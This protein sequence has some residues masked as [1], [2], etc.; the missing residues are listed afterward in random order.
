MA[1]KIHTRQGSP[2]PFGISFREEGINFALFSSSAAKV[3]LILFKRHTKEKVAQIPVKHKTGTVWHIL[4]AGLTQENWAHFCYA[5]QIDEQ[6]YQL[7]DPYAHALATPIQWGARKAPEEEYHPLGDLAVPA[8]TPFDWQEVSRPQHAIEDL[9]LYE[10]HVRGF[11][12]HPSSGVRYPGT[13]L[14][15]IEKIP[16][17]LALGINA[18]ELL[19][20][21]EF[22]E[23]E[24]KVYNPTTGKLLCNFWGYSTVNFFAP[25][26]RYACQDAITEFKTLVRELHRNGIEV[27]LDVVYNHTAEGSSVGPTLSYKALDKEVYYIL[28]PDGD[29]SNYSGCGNSVNANHPVVIQLILDSL[30]YWALE[31]HVDGFRF[32]LA[33]ALTR[34]RRGEPLDSAPLIDAISEDPLLANLKLIAEPWD[35]VGLYHVGRFWPTTARWSEWNGKYRDSVRCFIKGTPGV[36]GDFVTRLCGSED[37]YY[38]R[39]PTCS[40]NFVT[41]HD[42]F[43]LRDL[44]S[45]NEKHNI[46]NGENNRDGTSDNASWNCGEE[47]ETDK[48]NVLEL[49]DR[50]MR[51]FHLALMIS[52]GVPMLFMGDEY[53]HT[54]GGN[55]NTWCHDDER[56]WFLWDQLEQ[57]RGFYR[58]YCKLI[59]FR[60]QHPILR[61]TRFLTPADVTWHGILPLTPD[62]NPEN[63]FVAFT[64]V[65]PNGKNLYLAFNA[66]EKQI[67][68]ELP[69]AK[70]RWVVYTANPFPNDFYDPDEAP[71]V[72]T[73]TIPMLP[74]SALMLKSK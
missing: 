56:N 27:I 70:W 26:N 55:N 39:S 40:I 23:Q 4:L 31:M 33:S 28:N 58:Y 1:I 69:E 74:F 45:Y 17:L 15:L 47:G 30:R 42:G 29:Y 3:T 63:Q 32:D 73:P 25:M 72:D 46:D 8:R 22:D 34:G 54:K 14:G 57:N 13:F 44:V 11:T 2:E 9:I 41:V 43:T 5:Y 60:K 6:P 21:Q 48:E 10:M 59:Q 64:L 51:N 65:D 7:I 24:V 18:V 37:L 12:R 67:E 52:Q 19:P 49:R 62:W 66:Q 36:T 61:R 68:L 16:A 20:I 71:D 50:Q 35:A 38:N 53:G